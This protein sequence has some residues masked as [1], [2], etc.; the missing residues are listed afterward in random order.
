MNRPIPENTATGQPT[1]CKRCTGFSLPRNRKPRI[2]RRLAVLQVAAAFAVAPHMLAGTAVA[3]F[4]LPGE[5]STAPATEASAPAAASISAGKALIQKAKAAVAAKDYATA[6][7]HYREAGKM[8]ATVPALGPDVLRLSKQLADAGVDKELLSPPK[9]FSVGGATPIAAAAPA[10]VNTRKAEAL[11]LIA[12]GRA[13]LDRGDIAT[14]VTM[15]HRAESLN[16]PESAYAAGEP[17]VWQFMLDAKSAASKSGVAMTAGTSDAGNVMQTPFN[18]AAPGQA[19]AQIA[20]VQNAVPIT[21][22]TGTY[23]EELYRDGLELLSKGDA[24][25]AREK[26]VEA[27]KYEGQLPLEIRR[28]LQDKLTLVQ[29]SRLPAAGVTEPNRPLTAMEKADMEAQRATRR[30]YREVTAELAKT[31]DIKTDQPLEAIDNLKSLLRRVEG[32]NV[33]QASKR[34]LASMVERALRDQQTYVEAHR[35]EIDLELQNDA[36][37]R[38]I[39]E[40][41]A[42]EAMID[43]K[44]SALVDDYNVLM[45]EGRFEEAEVI[46]KEVAEL[47]PDDTI[48]INMFQKSRTGVRMKMYNEIAADKEDGFARQML[49]VDASA[50]PMD[51]ARPFQY[52]DALDWSEM[53]RRRLQDGARGRGRTAAEE[54]IYQKLDT[55]IDA[56]YVNQPIKSVMD[57]ISALTDIPIVIDNRALQA[58][59]MDSSQPVTLDLPGSIP[60][61]NALNLM[62]R[63]YDL[64]YMV[65]NDVLM[66]T[67]QDVKRSNVYPVTYRVTDLV[68]PIPNFSTSND[69]GLQSAMQA[70][71]QM[72]N[73]VANVQVM[74]VSATDLGAGI[75]GP[76][77]GN[78]SGMNNPMALGQYSP[79]GL[80]GAGI[81]QSEPLGGGSMADFSQLMMLIQTTIEPETWEAMGGTSTMFPYSANLSLVVSTT[82]DVHDQISDLLESLRRL[83]NL[84]ITIEVRF[85]TLSD[86]FFERIGVDFD[87]SFDDNAS[88]L[89][90]DDSGPEVTIG[91]SSP[92]IP[93]PDLDI[94]LS[95]NLFEATTPTF[96]GFDV[97]SASSIGFA[98][99]SDIEAFFFLQAVQGNGRS[100]VMQAPKVTLFDGQLATINDTSARPFVTSITP[101]VGDFAVAQ[102]PIITVL[103]EGT[104]LQVQGVVSDDKRYVRLTL[105][106]FFSQ[107]GDVNTFTFEGRRSTSRNV[108]AERDTNGDG[109]IDETDEE[110]EE[111][112]IEGTTVQL[113]TFASTSVSTTVNVPDGGTIMLG[114]IKRL[115][116]GRTERGVPFFSKIPY[117]SRLFR[118]VGIGRE[119]SSLMMMVTPRIII[120][121]EQELMQTGFTSQR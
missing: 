19:D 27:W 69:N 113:P 40:E 101:V 26:F 58:E 30:L 73:P 109:T 28:D 88:Q 115:S 52:G 4:A 81:P 121:E 38:T 90:D 60:L 75:A 74:P 86:T 24:P 108:A 92:G 65:D 18:G 11:R 31:N 41:N 44:V 42:R 6:V 15:A 46:A 72:A 16:V 79:S 98:I 70:A 71:Y 76:M 22:G 5:L 47:K 99:L 20:Q 7:K 93:T 106:P 82:S 33:D 103:N 95:N 110:T 34:S 91:L 43:S 10:D 39:D 67:T 21:V 112:I 83:Q 23:G 68:T 105:V 94:T 57:Q 117:V 89:P 2:R 48:A 1:G 12:V 35:A 53:S 66:I 84:Q 80:T 114:G 78:Q 3:Q 9:N 118:N 36:V 104:Q 50:V 77:A 87:V 62:L 59:R 100:N 49:G 97:N 32:A 25:A 85:I 63:D 29:P 56:N 111:D 96:G 14:A 102:Q 120:E 55:P 17:R 54:V 119:S 8:T 116:E 45:R 64:T 13:A 37:R 51:P 61:K 107:I